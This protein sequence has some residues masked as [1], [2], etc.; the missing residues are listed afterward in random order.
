MDFILFPLDTPFPLRPKKVPPPGPPPRRASVPQRLS[1][2]DR[3]ISHRSHTDQY[4]SF[5]KGMMLD[6]LKFGAFLLQGIQ[7][8]GGVTTR[9]MLYPEKH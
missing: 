3:N 2:L 4:D 6:V 7:R 8:P 9:K 1:P 5:T